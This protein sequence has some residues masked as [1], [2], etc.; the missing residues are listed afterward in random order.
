[1][2]GVYRMVGVVQ[3]MRGGSQRMV[4]N[5]IKQL[6]GVRFQDFAAQGESLYKIW[7]IERPEDPLKA[8]D[9]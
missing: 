7:M 5:H 6:A 1:M 3:T 2:W 4:E 9:L 8:E